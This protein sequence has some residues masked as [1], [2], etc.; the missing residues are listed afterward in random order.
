MNWFLFFIGILLIIVGIIL[1]IIGVWL[2]ASNN[3]NVWAW[4]LA[5]VGGIIFLVSFVITFGRLSEEYGKEELFGGGGKE[6]ECVETG[7]VY[8]NKAKVYENKAEKYR[9]LAEEYYAKYRDYAA[10]QILSAREN[11]FNLARLKRAFST[12]PVREEVVREEV[13]IIPTRE[14]VDIVREEVV[15]NV[16]PEPPRR[17]TLRGMPMYDQPRTVGRTLHC[18]YR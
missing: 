11:L 2:L 6:E 9:N 18:E 4:V 1:S 10:G 8:L 13:E 5:I 15:A 16:I 3:N 7:D 14:G 12:V 17:T